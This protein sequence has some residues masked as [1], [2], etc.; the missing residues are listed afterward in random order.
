MWIFLSNSFLSIT[1]E[2]DPGGAS[3][4]VLAWNKDD[5]TAIFPGAGVVEDEPCKGAFRAR[6]ER[7]VVFE[8]IAD[9][10]ESLHYPDLLASVR[11]CERRNRYR[12]VWQ[13]M[14]GRRAAKPGKEGL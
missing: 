5:I 2:G 3:L 8:V 13:I 6:I 9:R 14:E 7:R 11:D 1:D 10:I 4:L 12:E